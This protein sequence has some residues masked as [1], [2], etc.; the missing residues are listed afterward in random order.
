[1]AERQGNQQDEPGP[2]R[3]CTRCD[4]DLSGLALN[5]PVT[6]HITCPECGL[7]QPAILV[8]PSP[9]GPMPRLARGSLFGTLLLFLI[10]VV[11]V[12][13]MPGGSNS[14]PR[15][16]YKPALGAVAITAVAQSLILF[17]CA[18][19]MGERGMWHLF[20][21]IASFSLGLSIGLLVPALA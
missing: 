8:E 13:L 11:I 15:T 14:V 19:V 12:V 1:L 9:D 20:A 6:D 7:V 4:Y 10:A 16:P 17:I 18:C 5:N 21:S 2:Q 3:R